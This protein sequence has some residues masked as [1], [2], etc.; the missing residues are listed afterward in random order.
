MR[1][2]RKALLWTLAGLLIMFAIAL[3]FTRNTQPAY[4]GLT[5]TQWL[6]VV[7]R[8]RVNGYFTTY[9]KGRPPARDAT[10]EEIKE[11]ENAICAMGT[12]A[13]PCLLEWTGYK[14]GSGKRFVRGIIEVTIDK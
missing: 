7:A 1:N 12:N 9:Q 6:D 10:P 2:R 13:F 14:P 4:E 11:A 3:V 5:L 8:H